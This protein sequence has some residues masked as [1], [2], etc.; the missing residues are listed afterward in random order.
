MGTRGRFM[1]DS[2]DGLGF[3]SIYRCSGHS[4]SSCGLPYQISAGCKQARDRPGCNAYE[5]RIACPEFS[6]LRR[7][8]PVEQRALLQHQMEAQFT[9]KTPTALSR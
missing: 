6:I 4:F 3:A 9:F 2:G 7:S 8:L 5:D 1:F